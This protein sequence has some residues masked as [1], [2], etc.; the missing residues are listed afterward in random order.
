MSSRHWAGIRAGI[1]QPWLSFGMTVLDVILCSH[2]C[3][4]WWED[5]RG[6][7]IPGKELLVLVYLGSSG[8]TLAF[9]PL[10]NPPPPPPN[11]ILE[12]PFTQALRFALLGIQV[13]QVIRRP[14]NPPA[15]QCQPLHPPTPLS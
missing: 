10:Q 11:N 3:T 5:V 8:G 15:G 7:L 2:L 9:T 1:V 4:R 6:F 14:D 12:I 13:L